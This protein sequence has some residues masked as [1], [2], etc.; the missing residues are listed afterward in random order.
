MRDLVET[1]KQM[2]SEAAE[3][4][5]ELAQEIEKTF[6]KYF[7][8]SFIQSR[9]ETHLS[10]SVMVTIALAKDA[11]ESINNIIDNDPMITN[12]SIHLRGKVDSEGN[13]ITPIVAERFRG[14]GLSWFPAGGGE[15]QKV[16]V[17]FRKATGDTAK[18]VKAFDTH[19]KRLRNAVKENSK[20][21]S[22]KAGFDVNKKVR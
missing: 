19:F 2:V 4:A 16:K 17:P 6:K 18:I 10:P 20:S 14:I 1:Y 3:T 9:F 21:I 22:A 7:P 13:I 15:A 5:N 11:R 12:F 8:D